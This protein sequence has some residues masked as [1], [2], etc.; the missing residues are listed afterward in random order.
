MIYRQCQTSS[1]LRVLVK[2]VRLANQQAHGVAGLKKY[3]IKVSGVVFMLYCLVAAG[4]FG[5]EEMI[6]E[7]GPGITL[8]LLIVFP[9]IWSYP[10][11]SMVAE[12]GS[13]LPS[14][15]GIYVWVKE[16]FGEFWGFQANWWETISGY[17]TNG[18]YVALVAGYVSQMIPM[19]E[20]SLMVL[21][22]GMIA[23]FTFINLL[24]LREVDKVSTV[25]SISI[26]CA[27]ALVTVVGLLNWQS[28]PFEPV[29]PAESDPLSAIGSGL[30]ICVWMYCGFE[31]ISNMAGEIRNP[32]VIPRGL[33]IAMPLV[34][35]S[36]VLP[37][38]AG[39]A[40]LPDGSWA[41]WSTESGLD[42]ESVGYA[43]VLTT[44][45]GSAWGYVFLIVA[46]I[47]QCAIFN[48]YLAAT[49]RGLFVLSD[50]NLC[51]HFLVKVSEKRGVPYNGILSLA[52]V[53]V[54]LAQSD[55]TTLVSMEV[56]FILAL[57]VILPL[58]VIKLRRRIPVEERRKRGLYVMPGGKAGLVF[59]CGL[60]LCIAVFAMLTNGTDYITIGLLALISGP[61][62]Y[63]LVKRAYGGLTVNDPERHPVNPKTKL[64]PGDTARFALFA[65]I[66]GGFAFV[67]QFWLRWYEID[68]GGWGPADYVLWSNSIPLVLDVLQWI[69]L[70][71]LVA[72]VAAYLVRRKSDPVLPDVPFDLESLPIDY[73]HLP[74]E[75]RITET[76]K[77]TNTAKAE[78]A[79]ESLNLEL[80]EA[81]A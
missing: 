40:A 12:C 72:G 51:P 17:I 23:I 67:A 71:A 9:I 8:A 5:I 18:V 77:I 30:C 32:Q 28:N 48:T 56:M 68:H 6:P 27:F 62:A 63:T 73:S 2:G 16:A 39:L 20:T 59:Y 41:L 21:K 14:E 78:D 54:I 69:G 4:A 64:A 58:A 44:Y 38:L 24:G 45:L 57:Y 1:R 60:P 80:E 66:L 35:L 46:I 3:D 25:L 42:G 65:A 34:A 47:S 70:V 76:V 13:M 52:F 29:M 55:F 10:I 33:K 15:G 50:D 37:T 11:S 22:I 74:K 7:A 26:V 36:Y 75:G 31:C 61:I 53:T 49:S 43:T 79:E 19:N 81:H